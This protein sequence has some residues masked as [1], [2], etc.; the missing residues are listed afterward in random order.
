[1]REAYGIRVP[2]VF[3]EVDAVP[4]YA[5]ALRERVYSPLPRFPS[6]RRDIA[7][8]ADDAVEAERIIGCVRGAVPK[9]IERVELFDLFKGQQIPDD[10]KGLALSV[11]LRSAN[12]TLSEEEIESAMERIRSELKSLGCDIRQQ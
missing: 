1:V 7:L 11:V 9:L 12:S 3:A 5:S 6:A 2:V 8:V 10:K 4:I